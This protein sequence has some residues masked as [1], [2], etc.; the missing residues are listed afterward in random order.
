MSTIEQ[1]NKAIH[2]GSK[3]EDDMSR[4]II[5]S[6]RNI[7]GIEIDNG[8]FGLIC[9][10][11]TGIAFNLWTD[12]KVN[13]DYNHGNFTDIY[14]KD[15]FYRW[16]ICSFRKLILEASEKEFL[17]I[18]EK[19]IRDKIPFGVCVEIYFGDCEVALVVFPLTKEETPKYIK[20]L[21]VWK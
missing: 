14:T 4:L 11:S 9:A 16:R 18:K 19:L 1:I 3:C 21:K 20:F 17:N 10:H 6:K 8:H 13:F 12:V 5:I 7:N 2:V 15:R